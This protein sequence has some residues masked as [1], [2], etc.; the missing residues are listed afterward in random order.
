MLASDTPAPRIHRNILH[1]DS[2]PSAVLGYCF[3]FFVVKRKIEFVCL[4]FSN[5]F[6]SIS[7][8]F[9]CF[10]FFILL[11]CVFICSQ[12]VRPQFIGHSNQY[13]KAIIYFILSN[14]TTKKIYYELFRLKKKKRKSNFYHLCIFS[15]K[16]YNKS[17]TNQ[18]IRFSAEFSFDQSVS[19]SVYIHLDLEFN[20]LVYVNW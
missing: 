20:K 10:F 19:N 1:T 18:S 2:R 4:V 3:F 12:T 14:P 17:Y 6:F 9:D 11:I 15:I 5:W 16:F 8:G 13:T 7:T